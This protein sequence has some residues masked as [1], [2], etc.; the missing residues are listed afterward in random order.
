MDRRFRCGTCRNSSEKCMGHNGYIHLGFPV[1]HWLC[2]EKILKTLRCVCF[3]C[4][5]SIINPA[6]EDIIRR[7]STI[8]K[9]S[10]LPASISMYSK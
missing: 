7:F 3:W 1:Y 5:S 4:S 8:R 9:K 10:N 2:F 6:D